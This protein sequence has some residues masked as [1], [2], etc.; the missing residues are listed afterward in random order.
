VKNHHKISIILISRTAQLKGN[1][2]WVKTYLWHKK[3]ITLALINIFV[4]QENYYSGALL[5][6]LQYSL[7]LICFLCNF[8]SLMMP[9]LGPSSLDPII[10]N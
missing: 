1:F 10:I 3:I 5:W 7:K 6:F 8:L 4:A 2:D 9:S